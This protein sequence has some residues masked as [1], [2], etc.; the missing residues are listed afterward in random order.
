M[1]SGEDWVTAA[2]REL[3]EEMGIDVDEIVSLD[4]GRPRS[5]DD[6]EVSLI[7]RS[8]L[9]RHDGPVSFVDAEVAEAWWLPR[10]EVESLM[11]T[12]RFLPDSLAL[13]WPLLVRHPDMDWL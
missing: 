12:E 7:G 3:G 9:V 8:W 13:V 5:Y 6:D 4:E 11:T 1:A 2:R 10:H